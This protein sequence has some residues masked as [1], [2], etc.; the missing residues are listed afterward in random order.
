MNPEQ[1]KKHMGVPKNNGFQLDML[2]WVKIK[3]KLNN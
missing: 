3:M 1:Q 2:M